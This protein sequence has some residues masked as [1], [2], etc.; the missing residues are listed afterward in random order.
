[1][2]FRCLT[3]Q[4]VWTTIAKFNS[5]KL[6][7]LCLLNSNLFHFPSG[8]H[9]LEPT[10]SRRNLARDPNERARLGYR[11]DV[12]VEFTKLHWTPVVAC[13]EISGGL[14]RCCRNKEWTDTLKLSLELRDV[15][16]MAQDELGIVDAMN[17]VVWGFTVVGE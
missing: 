3:Q 4:S 15:W 9:T 10:A 5:K 12:I 7:F 2:S 1:M 14:P 8:E 13:G 16:T 6:V 17:L 11:V